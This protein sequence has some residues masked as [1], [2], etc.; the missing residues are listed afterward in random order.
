M[1]DKHIECIIN[2]GKLQNFIIETDNRDLN[3]SNLRKF[4]NYI[5]RH[6]IV[7][8]SKDI[9]AKYLLD[10]ACGRGGDMQ[11]WKEANLKYIFAFDSHKESI[12]NKSSD[13]AIYRL[14]ELLRYTKMPFI[15]FHNLNILDKDILTTINKL[16]K[17]NNLNKNKLNNFN[18]LYDI[19]SCQF[20]FHY[21]SKNND[22]LNHVFNTISNKLKLGGLFI[23]TATDG[24][25]IKKILALGDVDIPLLTLLNV[26]E[27]DYIFNIKTNKNIRKTYFELQGE[28]L[29]HYLLKKNFTEIALKHDLEVIEIKSF[30]EWYDKRFNLNTYEMVISFLNFSFILK[31]IK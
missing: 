29:E 26:N 6:L 2:T 25:K 14:K 17:Y 7:S 27:S 5:K 30:N 11:K 18:G 9:N 24:D 21:F 15:K 8:N 19:V 22:S 3:I 10:I 31:K 23:G 4:H 20:A 16:E 1:S 12:V 13:G 28:S